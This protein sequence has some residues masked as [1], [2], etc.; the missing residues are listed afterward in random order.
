MI[1]RVPLSRNAPSLSTNEN[2]KI[3]LQ[4][5]ATRANK[6]SRYPSSTLYTFIRDNRLLPPL[7]YH[8]ARMAMQCLVVHGVNPQRKGTTCILQSTRYRYN[9]NN[10]NAQL[11]VH[12]LVSRYGDIYQISRVLAFTD[13]LNSYTRP[14]G[15]T[16]SIKTYR[17]LPG[18]LAL[19]G[20][21]DKVRL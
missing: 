20:T 21:N 5:R 2:T 15:S 18:I 7:T 14:L 9:K 8:Y 16:A 12:P 13:S 19:M 3:H 1:P 6:I 11:T 17:F 4:S 10:H